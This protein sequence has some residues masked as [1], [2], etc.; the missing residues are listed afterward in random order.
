MLG[1]DKRPK[2][3]GIAANIPL[4]SNAVKHHSPG[5]RLRKIRELRG[6]TLGDVEK[7]SQRISKTRQDS[8]YLISRT[9]VNQIEHSDSLP[10]IYKLA[11]LSEIYGVPYAELLRIYGIETD[12]MHRLGSPVDSRRL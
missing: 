11:S 3:Y 8:Q 7:Q 5:G 6:M 12:P 2:P 9:R 10:S 1:S 4:E